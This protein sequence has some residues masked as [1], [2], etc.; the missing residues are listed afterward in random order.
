MAISENDPDNIMKQLSEYGLH[1]K[2]VVKRRG[3]CELL[4]IIRSSLTEY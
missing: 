4:Y 2:V 3:G 1:S